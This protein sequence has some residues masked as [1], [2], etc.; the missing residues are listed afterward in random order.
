VKLN[1]EIVLAI[2]MVNLATVM[3]NDLSV[4]QGAVI[5]DPVN[6]TQMEDTFNVT[7]LSE[8]DPP[9]SGSLFGDVKQALILLFTLNHFIDAFPN[10]LSSMGVPALM[11]GPIGTIMVVIWWLGVVDLISGGNML[12]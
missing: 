11:T 2:L 3:V 5:I 9:E 10:T 6:E 8:W 12:G 1:I 7:G 4:F